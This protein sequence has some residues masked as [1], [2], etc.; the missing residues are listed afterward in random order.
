[1]P[2]YHGIL[3]TYECENVLCENKV[4]K[5]LHNYSAM[6]VIQIKMFIFTHTLHVELA[7]ILFHRYSKLCFEYRF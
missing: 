5:S 3:H 6:S 2:P 1:M 4:L 7:Q